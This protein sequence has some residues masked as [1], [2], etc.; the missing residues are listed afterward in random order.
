MIDANMHMVDVDY[1]AVE[2]FSEDAPFDVLEALGG[3]GAAGNVHRNFR[4]GS[5]TLSIT[6]GDERSAML[7]AIDVSRTALRGA[8]IKLKNLRAR[9]ATD[10]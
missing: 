1:V 4:Q 2:S 6:T 9:I 10:L 7:E 8:G 5:L 3:Y